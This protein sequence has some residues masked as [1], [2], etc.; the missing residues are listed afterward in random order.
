MWTFNFPPA[1]SH[2]PLLSMR[3]WWLVMWPIYAFRPA[4]F[5]PYRINPKPLTY[6]PSFYVWSLIRVLLVNGILIGMPALA[7]SYFLVRMTCEKWG[8]VGREG[9]V[10]VQNVSR[11]HPLVVLSGIAAG[12]SSMSIRHSF[13]A[14]GLSVCVF[15]HCCCGGYAG[16]SILAWEVSRDPPLPSSQRKA[17]SSQWLLKTPCFTGAIVRCTLRGFTSGSTRYVWRW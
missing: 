6:T 16:A 9:C 11:A 8:R 12:A 7:P 3:R 14:T 10:W 17:F 1:S 13:R 5:E 4:I 15:S 2:H